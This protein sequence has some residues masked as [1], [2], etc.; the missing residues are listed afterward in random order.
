M[1]DDDLVARGRQGTD[2]VVT[3][4]AVAR[5]SQTFQGVIAFLVS[6]QSQAN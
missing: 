4:T 3:A 1:H 6:R 2:P 5:V